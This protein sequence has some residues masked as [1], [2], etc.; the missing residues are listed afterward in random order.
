MLTIGFTHR[1]RQIVLRDSYNLLLNRLNVA[2]CSDMKDAL[3]EAIERAG[4]HN[5]LAQKLGLSRQAIGRWRGRVPAHHARAVE[6]VTGVSRF[7]LRPDVFGD[8]DDGGTNSSD[9]VAA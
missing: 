6:R 5:R 2:I 7:R 9:H 8:R 4:G 3:Q 1:R